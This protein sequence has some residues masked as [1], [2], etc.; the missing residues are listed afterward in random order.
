MGR[1]WREWLRAWV[2]FRTVAE[3]FVDM[4]D[5]VL[6]LVEFRGRG[7]T[8]G[9]SVEA[10]EGAIVFSLR[11]GKVARLTTYT[12]RAEALEAAGLSG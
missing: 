10:M 7:K 11:D 8:S 2:D 9:V 12:D 4:G 6:V 3:E 1:A 5:E